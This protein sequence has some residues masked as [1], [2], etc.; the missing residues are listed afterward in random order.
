[1][2]LLCFFQP[3]GIQ[4]RKRRDDEEQLT[5]TALD[6]EPLIRTDECDNAVLV[7]QGIS[8]TWHISYISSA[9]L[10]IDSLRGISY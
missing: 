5:A 4:L 1:M 6:L 2:K 3:L 7:V 10:N 8:S 9:A